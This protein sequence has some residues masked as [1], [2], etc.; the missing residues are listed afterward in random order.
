MAEYLRRRE[1][2]RPFKAFN[3]QSIAMRAITRILP[4]IGLLSA[5]QGDLKDNPQ[6]QQLQEDASRSQA[7]AAERDSTINALFGTINRIGENLSTI[8]A[9]Q[10]Q[11]GQP[12]EGAEQADM[13]QRIMADLSSIDGLINENKELIAR[14]RKQAKASASNI[15]ELEKT[16][17]GLEGSM[18][19]KDTEISVLK[20]QLA[21]SNSSLATLIEMY[22]D[23]SQ[24]SDMQRAD[25]NTA[26]YAIGTA[27]ELRANGVLAKEGGVVGIGAVN[28]LNAENLPK[29][30]FTRIDITRTQEIALA[31]KK[32]KLATT[33]PAG[34]YRLEGDKLTITDANQ[35][36]S[37]SKYLVVIV[38]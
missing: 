13:E 33:H 6:Y 35:F 15:A 24:L 23:K 1:R 28:K 25:L 9:K 37:V 2:N 29:D 16:I 20:E 32:A 34:S 5:C 36:W 4:L 21:S 19:E 17:A 22:R 7:L 38:E 31:A 14:L 8:R 3:H 30:Y 11:L 26:F 18:A 12:G 27:K 10:G